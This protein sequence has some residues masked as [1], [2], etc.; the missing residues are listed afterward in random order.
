M[1][2]RK[3]CTLQFP[4]SVAAATATAGV[5]VASNHSTV[6]CQEEHK[7]KDMVAIYLSPDSQQN[8]KVFLNE[9]GL[10]DYSGKYVVVTRLTDEKGEFIYQPLFGERAAFRLKGIGKADETNLAV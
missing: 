9:H 4:K 6:Q 5:I 7:V 8:L 10:S 2:W 3:F 1:M